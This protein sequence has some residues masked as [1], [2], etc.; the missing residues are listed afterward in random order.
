MT[1]KLEGVR[2][3]EV[4]KKKFYCGFPK[5]PNKKERLNPANLVM[6]RATE[7]GRYILV[8]RTE[9]LKRTLN[10]HWRQIKI[11]VWTCFRRLC[12][13][14]SNKSFSYSLCILLLKYVQVCRSCFHPFSSFSAVNFFFN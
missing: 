11:K 7:T 14:S 6:C 9:H 2:I 12:F 13:L 4:T 8:H 10:P 5:V 3:F 1:T